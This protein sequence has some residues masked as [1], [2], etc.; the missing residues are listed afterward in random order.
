MLCLVAAIGYGAIYLMTPW[1]FSQRMLEIDPRL[2]LVP[3]NLSTKIEVPLSYTTIDCY[4]FRISLPNEEITST[5]QG[6]LITT[7]FFR[8][9]GALM[10]DNPSEEWRIHKFVISDKRAE[11]WVGQEAVHSKFKLMQAAMSVTPEQTKWWRFRNFENERVEY[12]LSTKF[13]FLAEAPSPYA[14]TLRPIYAISA[15][16]LRGFQIGNPDVPPYELHSDL[17]DGADRYFVLEVS[18]P[19][20]HG[21]VLTQAEVNAIVASIRPTT[22]H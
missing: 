21:Q 8:K 22:D 10:I 4:G 20:G 14:L 7:V 13:A 18:G 3:V 12:L 2:S 15:G 17:F 9:G 19:K 1:L 6:D 5:F 16:G 11:R